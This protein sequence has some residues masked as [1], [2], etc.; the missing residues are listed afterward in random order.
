M[1]GDL[2]LGSAG[3]G[4]QFRKLVQRGGADIEP[5]GYS[6]DGRS[7][8][9]ESP[10]GLALPVGSYVRLETEDGTCYLGQVLHKEIV[11]REGAEVSLDVDE[12]VGGAIRSVRATLVSLIWAQ[13]P[14]SSLI[15]RP[16]DVSVTRPSRSPRP[17]T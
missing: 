8:Q 15:G 5:L 16:E 2:T 14:P 10:L 7:F 12:T 4:S 17:C 3:A 9:F 13:R 1:A 6:A 11:S